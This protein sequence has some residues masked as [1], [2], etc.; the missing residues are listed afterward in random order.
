MSI[1]MVYRRT[2]SM[3]VAAALCKN[4][5]GKYRIALKLLCW[6]AA[7]NQKLQEL[8]KL[9]DGGQNKFHYLMSIYSNSTK[10]NK[11][12]AKKG[13]ITNRKVVC[14]LLFLWNH[15]IDFGPAPILQL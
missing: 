12:H 4:V 7:R 10:L 2:S 1:Y 13:M 9:Y 5:T 14:T 6:E 11:D 8:T 3:N 15:K